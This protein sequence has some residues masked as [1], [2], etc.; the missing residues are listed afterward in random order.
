MKR[1][2]ASCAWQQGTVSGYGNIEITSK[3]RP[4]LAHITYRFRLLTEYASP[5]CSIVVLALS[6]VG[7]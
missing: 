6:E 2:L 4:S 3:S 5:E 1:W 7:Q